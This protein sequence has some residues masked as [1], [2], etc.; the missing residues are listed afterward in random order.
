MAT[1]LPERLPRFEV[2]DLVLQSY[3]FI[4]PS[5]YMKG[6]QLLGPNLVRTIP[7]SWDIAWIPV[8]FYINLLKPIVYLNK[9]YNIN[10]KDEDT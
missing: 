2:S 10:Q 7:H 9:H 4:R 5:V 8:M 1:Q 6:L 3:T